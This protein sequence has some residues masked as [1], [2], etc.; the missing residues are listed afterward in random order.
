L[1]SVGRSSD[2]WAK[3]VPCAPTARTRL[4]LASAMKIAARRIEVSLQ[5][6]SQMRS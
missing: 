6:A 4:R 1:T 2:S 3:S 5:M